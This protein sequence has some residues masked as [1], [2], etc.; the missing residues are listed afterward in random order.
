MF[1]MTLGFP[2]GYIMNKWYPGREWIW[3][4]NN[5]FEQ[6]RRRL[7]YE[8]ILVKKRKALS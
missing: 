6:H 1:T 4:R 7:Q 3:D 5:E 2:T 8:P